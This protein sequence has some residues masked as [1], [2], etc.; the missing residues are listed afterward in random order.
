MGLGHLVRI[1]AV[2][3]ALQARGYRNHLLT[4]SM[5]PS[6]GARL[7]AAGHGVHSLLATADEVGDAEA[8]GDAVERLTQEFER[9]P[10][11]ILVDHYDLGEEWERRIR[12]RF[13]TAIVAFDDLDRH[14]HCDVLVDPTFA[15]GTEAYGDRTPPGATLLVGGRHAPLR[16]EFLRARSAMPEPR[17]EVGGHTAADP[18]R[19]LVMM[20]GTDPD[21]RTSYLLEAIAS[22]PEPERLEVVVMLGME[23]AQTRGLRE[24]MQAFPFRLRLAV[25][26]DSVPDCMMAADLCIGAAGSGSWERCCLGLPS[27]CVV[28][29]DNQLEV[30]ARL[31]AHGIAVDGGDLRETGALPAPNEWAERCLVPLLNGPDLRRR[32][33]EAGRGA[34]DGLGAHRI[35]GHISRAGALTRGGEVSMRS[36]SQADRELLFAWQRMDE[37]RAFARDRSQPS[38]QRHC[39][40]FAERL[41]RARSDL[42]VTQCGGVPAGVFR[43]DRSGNAPPEISILIDPAFHG[44][45]VAKAAVRQGMEQDGA[46]VYRAE[47]DPAN[48]ASV[49]LFASLGFSRMAGD[50]RIWSWNRTA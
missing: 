28:L 9:P 39:Q 13:G 38:W 1:G 12:D 19:I 5:P 34:I 18:L 33:S 8:F 47:V 20:G 14:H 44:M 11:A 10:D 3:S 26:V 36:A 23:T 22:L 15:K 45:G 7:V 17:S 6:V 37:T 42:W 27:I 30:A 29:A 25:D 43:L 4:V 41:D 50:A 24:R 21:H 48:T 40:W 2:A 49:R 31:V 16:D 35:A 46:A 32:L